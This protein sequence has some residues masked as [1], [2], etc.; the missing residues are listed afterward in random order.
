MEISKLR[1]EIRSI[2]VNGASLMMLCRYKDDHLADVRRDVISILFRQE[3]GMSAG[4]RHIRDRIFVVNP[5]GWPRRGRARRG[6]SV[7]KIL[8]LIGRPESFSHSCSRIAMEYAFFTGGAAGDPD[9]NFVAGALARE[10]IGQ[11]FLFKPIERFAIA[12]EAA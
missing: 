2:L 4:K 1:Q 10:K 9:A 12:E 6:T 7:A 5:G 11:H 3:I 8:T